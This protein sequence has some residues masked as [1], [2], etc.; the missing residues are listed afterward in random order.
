MWATV[1]TR[2]FVSGRNTTAI[3][4]VQVFLGRACEVGATMSPREEVSKISPL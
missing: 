3:V 1:T 4:A 2:L